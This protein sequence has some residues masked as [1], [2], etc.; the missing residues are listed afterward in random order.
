MKGSAAPPGEPTGPAAGGRRLRVAIAD[1]SSFI[2]RAIARLLA[3]EPD[4]QLVGSAGSGEELLD[5]IERWN[6]DAVVLDL[7]MPGMGGLAT[8]DRIM[9]TRPTPVL[10]LSTHSKKDAPQTIEALHRGA[11]DFIDKQQYSLVDFDALRAVLLEKLRQIT[12]RPTGG[13][14]E[15]RRPAGEAPAAA[16]APGSAGPGPAGRIEVVLVGASTGGPPAVE[17]LLRDFGTGPVAPAPVVI[18]QHM[19]AGFTRAF[20]ERL[21]AYLPLQVR[22][23]AHQE[24]LLPGTVYI[25]PGGLHLRVQR[26]A[27][28]LRAALSTSPETAI[29]RPAVDVLFASAAEAVGNRAVAALLTGMGQDGAAGMTA[30]ARA[31]AHTLAQDEA[32]SVVYGMPRAAILAGAAREVLPLERIGG[33]LRELVLAEESEPA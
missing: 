24:P 28:G 11:M 7:S 3:Q 31:G 32:T 10:I 4:L 6:P 22:E 17:A 9:A 12:G 1:D 23:A 13:A 8:L 20:A 14:P 25:A 21:N 18:V 15:P 27:G 19:P 33:R 5:Q 16:P 2:R 26:E 29:H 30:L